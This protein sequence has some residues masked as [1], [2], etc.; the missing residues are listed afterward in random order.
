MPEPEQFKT[1]TETM[2]ANLAT[3]YFVPAAV[4]ATCVPWPWQST[5]PFPSLIAENPLFDNL[6]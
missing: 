3:P 6:P 2:F 5:G 4:P 1:R